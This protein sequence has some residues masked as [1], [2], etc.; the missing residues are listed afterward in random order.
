MRVTGISGTDAVEQIAGYFDGLRE[1]EVFLDDIDTTPKSQD[2]RMKFLTFLAIAITAALSVRAQVPQ[3]FN[4]QAIVRGNAGTVIANKPLGMRFS[5]RD[6]SATGTVQY[7]ETQL[8]TS[9]A[10]G[11]VNLQVGAGTVA[12]GSFAAITWNTGN[13]F[14]QVEVDT[15]GSANYVALATVELI[16]VP[17]ALQA[18]RASITDSARMADSSRAAGKAGLS[19]SA[20]I[21]GNAKMADSARAAKTADGFSGS[22]AGDVAG[23]QNATVIQPGAITT[24]KLATSAVQT[25]QLADNSVTAAKIPAGQV[26]KSINGLKDDVTFAVGGGNSLVTNGSTITLNGSGTI[27]EVTA[28]AGLVGGGTSGAV[29]LGVNFLGDGFFTAVNHADHTHSGALWTTA[30]GNTLAL[31]TSSASFNSSALEADVT[32]T[33]SQ[34]AAIFAQTLSTNSNSAGV[35]GQASGNGGA[36]G[37]LGIG[38][39]NGSYAILGSA[40]GTGSYAGV[41][42]GNVVVTGTLSKGA[43]SFKIDHPLDPANKYLSHSFVESPDMMNIYNGNIILDAKGTATITMPDW[44]EAL[45]RGFRYQLTAIGKPSPNLYIAAEISG[46]KFRIAGGTPGAKV[47]WTV[48]GIRHDAYANAHRIPVE[49]MKKGAER[50]KYLNPEVFGV[51]KQQGVF[52]VPNVQSRKG[53]TTTPIASPGKAQSR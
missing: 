8:T 38:L 43:G 15:T 49:E 13:K 3:K 33:S 37:L 7:S 47:S 11:L 21:A 34:A 41:F 1:K 9:N 6:G 53:T 17:Y 10:Y 46:N 16:T 2:N 14:L 44:F 42:S 22:L 4:Y 31:Q 45:N 30:T 20:R 24:A 35:V 12:T 48:T 18:S 26:I 28:G 32:N 51:S 5:I 29:T 36:A 25:L 23:P 52:P 40:Q 39:G 50:G 27:S 19:D